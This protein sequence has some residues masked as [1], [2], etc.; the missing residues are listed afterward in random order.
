MAAATNLP[1]MRRR[2][3]IFAP[4]GYSSVV[5]R[6]LP[7]LNVRGS[8]PLTRSQKPPRTGWFFHARWKRAK[9]RIEEAFMILGENQRVNAVVR[10]LIFTDNHLLVTQ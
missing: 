10:G 3:I 2:D 1:R 6:Q 9:Y 5:E 4:S 8:S 7:K